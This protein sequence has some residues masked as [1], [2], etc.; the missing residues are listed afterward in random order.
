M[1]Y[2]TI[3]RFKKSGIKGLISRPVDDL[4]FMVLDTPASYGAQVVR[5]LCINGGAGWPVGVITQK[6]EA[7]FRPCEESE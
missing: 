4:R 2:G 7:L 5:L 3:V 6:N 1:K